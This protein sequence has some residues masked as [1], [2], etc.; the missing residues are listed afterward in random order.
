FLG[1]NKVMKGIKE[2]RDKREVSREYK[3]HN[4]T[5]EDQI[6]AVTG[7]ADVAYKM[8]AGPNSREPS[9]AGEPEDFPTSAREWKEEVRSE[10]EEKHS[11]D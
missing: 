5:R 1:I 11:E 6:D 9:F 2:N 4:T 8:I 7:A 10:L 3:S